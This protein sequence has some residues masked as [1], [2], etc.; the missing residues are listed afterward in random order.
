MRLLSLLSIRCSD[1]FYEKSSLFVYISDIVFVH[2]HISE[3]NVIDCKNELRLSSNN[4]LPNG[5]QIIPPKPEPE[6]KPEPQLH[7][8]PKQYSILKL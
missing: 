8:L 2:F 4:I 5:K 7:S 3:W 1:F 6:P